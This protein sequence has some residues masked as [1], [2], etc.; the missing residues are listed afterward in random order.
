MSVV[1]ALRSR[2][3]REEGAVFLYIEPAR[4]PVTMTVETQ[5]LNLHSTATNATMAERNND[6]AIKRRRVAVVE[7][8]LANIDVVSQLASFLEAEDL[9]QVKAT[10]KALGSANDG[11]NGLSMVDEAARR[12]RGRIGRGEGDT[13]AL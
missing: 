1:L 5:H 2:A 3:A 13:T 4:K 8:A 10:C 7:S 11:A 6:G 12:I 9:C